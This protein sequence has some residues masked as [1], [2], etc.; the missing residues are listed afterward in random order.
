MGNEEGDGD[1]KVDSTM[2]Y[3]S[4]TFK[5]STLR[6]FPIGLINGI[7]DPYYQSTNTS[8]HII[9]KGR[10]SAPQSYRIVFGLIC[11]HSEFRNDKKF[12]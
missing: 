3:F 2:L 5:A 1:D 6:P 8:V 9:K 4:G 12:N 7:R 10:F 11:L